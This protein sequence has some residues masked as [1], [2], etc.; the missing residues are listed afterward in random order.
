MSTRPSPVHSTISPQKID[1]LR[2]A[3]AQCD[4]AHRRLFDLTGKDFLRDLHH[5]ADEYQS[6]RGL[7]PAREIPNEIWDDAIALAP[8]GRKTL[9][10]S[11]FARRSRCNVQGEWKTMKGCHCP[12]GACHELAVFAPLGFSNEP[13]PFLGTM[14]VPSMKHSDKSNLPRSWRYWAK[15]SSASLNT[16]LRA[17]CWNLWWQVWYEGKRSG[18]S[19]RRAPLL[20]I[21]KMPFITSRL[22]R[23]GRPRPSAR[24]DGSGIRTLSSAHCSSVSS[25]VSSSPRRF[26]MP[27]A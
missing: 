7:P 15:T 10:P 19:C 13:S 8:S 12:E 23:H 1:R 16:P 4:K 11:P 21:H 6:A 18:R 22:S 25:S 17:H 9:Q 24:R 2:A 3:M 27:S 20:N 26:A 14:N 5:K